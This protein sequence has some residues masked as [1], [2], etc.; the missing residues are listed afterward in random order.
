MYYI[1]L[2]NLKL[3]F[4]LA[5]FE[6]FNHLMISLSFV[7]LFFL[8]NKQIGEHCVELTNNVGYYNQVQMP[9]RVNQY[10][11]CVFL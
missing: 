10:N 11:I 6:V 1:S 2:F 8:F 7:W 4:L 9:Y 3:S 5:T